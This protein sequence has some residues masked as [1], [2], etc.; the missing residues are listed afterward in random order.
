MYLTKP[1]LLEYYKVERPW[2]INMVHG[3]ND[4]ERFERYL[5]N[6]KINMFEVDME[7]NGNN[8]EE[9]TLQHEGVGNVK[10]AWAI[11]KLVKHKKAL[12]L[13]LKLLN[14]NLYRNE[15]CIHALDMIRK[16]W[17][18]TIPIWIHADILR[19]PNWENSNH[20]YLNPT[21]FVHLYNSYHKDNPKATISL[22]YLTSYKKD[23]PVKPYTTGMVKQMQKI[24]KNVNGH[25]TIALRYINLMKYPKMLQEFL[26][27][28]SVTIW[29]REDTITFNQFTRLKES[30]RSLNVFKDLTEPNRKPMWS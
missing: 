12:K 21:D 25:T 27:L 23:T 9:I 4:K 2:D 5:N 3:V 6:H 8:I 16:Y 30:M 1:F 22:G 11:D 29:N 18:P 7:D 13:D 15:F 17:D 26:K 14:G 10:F 19:G 24:I 28:G 20:E